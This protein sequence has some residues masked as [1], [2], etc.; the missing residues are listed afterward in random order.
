MERQV[1]VLLRSL[2]CD[3]N[4][5]DAEMMLGLLSE[6]GF[7]LTDDESQAEA[8]IVNTCCFIMDAKQESIDC[9]IE[10]GRLKEEG[11]CRVLIAAGCLAQRYAAE[12][13]EEIPEVD[14]I[15][16][17]ASFDH[18]A[19]VLKSC[20]D[21][22]PADSL[23]D[24]SRAV[25]GKKRILSTGG[26]YAHLKI[27]EGC[28]KRCSYCAIPTFR[29]HYRSVP[30]EVLMA[31]ARSLVEGGVRELILVAQETTRYGIDLYGKKSLSRLLNE[32]CTIED[33]KWIRILYC[34]PEEIDDELIETIATQ[35][36]ICHYLDMPVQHSEDGILKRMGRATRRDELKAV[37]E[38]MRSRIPDICLRTTMISG[39]PGESDEDFEGLKAFIAEM[40]FE[41]L[42][43]F[44]YSPEEGTA[45]AEMPDQIADEVKEER[46]DE[47]MELQ[48][49]IAFEQ[50]AELEGKI[51]ECMVEGSIP[52]EH[53]LVLRSYRDAPEVDGYV[54]VDTDREY[55]S[56]SILKVKISGSEE[57]DLIGEIVQ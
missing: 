22:K 13:H 41:R 38:K 20:L 33:L 3:K 1:K 12:I 46:R 16:G 21:D 23:E 57:Y 48:Q 55:M 56:G 43:V 6:A 47:L 54:F 15:V 5:V 10:Y 52:E 44:A 49:E 4:L 50:A 29:G 36:K 28:D 14:A 37:I 24:M 9:L 45:A 7:E 42:G 39:F 18:I 53:V 2:G 27:A 32:L 17:T 51:I 25:Y 19:E 35:P 30:I 11:R 31:E 8:V 26:H 40:R 34:Y